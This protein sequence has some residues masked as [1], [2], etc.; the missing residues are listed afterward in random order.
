MIVRSF[1]YGPSHIGV[2]LGSTNTR[3]AQPLTV[4]NSEIRILL[5]SEI[6]KVINTHHPEKLV[7][8][9]SEQLSA[10]N[11]LDFASQRSKKFSLPLGKSPM[12][13]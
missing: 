13:P 12:K 8:G 11:S 5:L 3:L 10:K 7:V 1:D 4:I 6:G 9:I 2:A